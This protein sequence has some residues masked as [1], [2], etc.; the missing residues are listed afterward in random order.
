MLAFFVFFG[1]VIHRCSHE[2]GVGGES[3]E[4]NS[5]S[6]HRALARALARVTRRRRGCENG[7]GAPRS[8]SCVSSGRCRHRL[9]VAYTS[10]EGGAVFK[11]PPVVLLLASA[12]EVVGTSRAPRLLLS[13]KVLLLLLGVVMMLRSSNRAPIG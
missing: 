7:A 9:R 4:R 1:F 8:T 3:P 10:K 5:H 12:R 6:A 11:A 2:A 13:F